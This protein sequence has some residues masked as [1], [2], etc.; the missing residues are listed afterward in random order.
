MNCSEG[1]IRSLLVEVGKQSG[2]VE[3]QT[4]VQDYVLG[5]NIVFKYRNM[6]EA[7]KEFLT[8]VEEAINVTSQ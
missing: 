3:V 2:V 1:N 7:A 6:F 4:S 5:P 8:H